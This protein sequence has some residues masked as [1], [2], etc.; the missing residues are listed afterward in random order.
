M[1][2]IE[3]QPFSVKDAVYKLQQFLLEGVDGEAQLLAAGSILSRRDYEDVAVERSIANL[4]GYPLCANPLPS[5]RPRKGRYRIS[6]K[7]HKVYDL[8]ETYMYCSPGCVV[9][10]RAFAGSLQPE[11][12][13]VLDLAK[14]GEVLRVFGNK[15]LGEEEEEGV[16]GVGDLGMSGL[17][18]KEREE[19]RAGEVSSEEW[20]G[21]SNAIEGYVPRRRDD[22]PAATASGV[23]KERREGKLFADSLV[24]R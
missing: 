13:A 6:L 21:P 2:K 22:K 4:C 17:K 5:D 1:V 3:E 24:C 10:S 15:G 18:I 9:N 20:I 11:R 16:D 8:H 19:N 14:I 12:C 23:K 7:E